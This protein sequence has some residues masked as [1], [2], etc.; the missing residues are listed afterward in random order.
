MVLSPTD[1]EGIYILMEK[2]KRG[3]HRLNIQKV[4]RDGSLKRGS[5]EVL[6]RG[7][8]ATPHPGPLL[9]RGGEGEQP[10]GEVEVMVR[11]WLMAD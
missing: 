10:A 5:V 6:E 3:K 7:A 9:D 2:I 8:K 11:W 1:Y 4:G